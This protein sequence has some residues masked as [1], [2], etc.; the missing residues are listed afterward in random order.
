METFLPEEGAA[1]QEAVKEGFCRGLE[2]EILDRFSMKAEVRATVEDGAPKSAVILLERADLFGDAVG[3]VHYIEST[4]GI[5][6]TV[7]YKTE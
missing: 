1:W 6:V 2:A 7:E 3:M 4:F 5:D